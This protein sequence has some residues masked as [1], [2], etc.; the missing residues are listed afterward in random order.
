[1]LSNLIE[2]GL[3]QRKG[4]GA[5]QGNDE[6]RDISSQNNLGRLGIKPPIELGFV[7]IGIPGDKH[8]SRHGDELFN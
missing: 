3:G 2:D 4:V 7:E 1:V 5:I 6:M 8:L